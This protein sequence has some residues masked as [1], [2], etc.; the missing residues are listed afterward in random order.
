ML[1]LFSF[2]DKP[3]CWEQ[4]KALCADENPLL[5]L[6]SR[7]SSQ[8]NQRLS[9]EQDCCWCALSL[10]SFPPCFPTQE[11]II[12]YCF[13]FYYTL[14]D[15]LLWYPCSLNRIPVML[16]EIKGNLKVKSVAEVESSTPYMA[17]QWPHLLLEQSLVEASN[18]NPIKAALK[19]R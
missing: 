14:L 17:G 19:H 10:A 16:F 12:F 13:F 6:Y 5:C 2:L 15:S 7:A 11:K 1:F 3:F 8:T 18:K 4:S 9:L